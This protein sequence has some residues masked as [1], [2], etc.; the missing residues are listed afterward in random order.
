MRKARSL[1]FVSL[2]VGCHGSTPAPAPESLLAISLERTPCFGSCP[3]YRVTIS[4][5]GMVR[6]QG[7]RFVGHVG[8]D[9]AQIAKEA[10]DSLLADFDRGGFYDFE[11]QYVSGAPGC[12]LYATDLP[13]ANTA[14][15]D[16]SRDKRVQ[17][18]RG[19]SEA[20]QALSALEDRIDEVAGTARWV[21]R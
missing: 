8:A 20:P 9:S 1:L 15:N 11:E 4:R 19:C 17:H 12:G 5:G 14:V 13:S 6:F 3:V 16:G 2:L 10:V 18:D 21:A 7:T